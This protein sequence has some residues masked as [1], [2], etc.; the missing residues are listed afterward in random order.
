MNERKPL[1]EVGGRFGGGGGGGR[2]GGRGGYSGGG[3]GGGGQRLGES[4]QKQRRDDAGLERRGQLA[5]HGRAVQVDPIKPTLKAPG[6][7]LSKLSYDGPVSIFAFNFNLH[8][9][10]TGSYDGLARIWD[11]QGNLV[12][13]LDQHKVGRCRL[14]L[15]NPH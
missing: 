1:G 9:Y 14:T 5:C 4:Q 12:N 15:S 3:R 2:H 10:T 13:S 8:R 11:T 7:M 6:S